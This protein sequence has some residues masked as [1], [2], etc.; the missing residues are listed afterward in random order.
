M[1]L[2]SACLLCFCCLM[3]CV[4]IFVMVSQFMHASSWLALIY[5][6]IACFDKL[7]YGLFWLAL[8]L[9]RECESA[10]VILF[11]APSCFF[12]F[13]SSSL[14][15]LLSSYLLFDHTSQLHFCRKVIFCITAGTEFIRLVKNVKGESH[16]SLQLFMLLLTFWSMMICNLS[17]LAHNATLYLVHY[18]DLGT[19]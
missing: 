18:S 8:G 17:Q 2:R 11:T 5:L 15:S 6:I 14:S 9:F 19:D 1:S 3:F 16:V 7:N 12:S 10:V 13:I 4:C